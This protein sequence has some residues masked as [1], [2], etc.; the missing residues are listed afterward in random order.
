MRRRDFLAA[1]GGLLIWPLAVRAQQPA[2]PVIG[3]LSSISEDASTLAAFHR[4]LFQEGYVEGRNV[5]IEHRYARGQYDRLPALARELASVNVI[6]AVGSSPA[7]LAAKAATPNIPIVF[8]LGAD[9]VGLGLVASYNSPGGNITGVSITPTSLTPKRLE[10]LDGLVAKGAPL[11]L[12]VNPTNRLLDE[13]LKLAHDAARLLARDLVVLKAGSQADIDAAFEALARRQARGL[14]IW[15]E[16]FLNSRRQQIVAL[17][18]RQAIP[19]VYPWRAAVEADG[20]M[21][22]GAD[23]GDAYRQVGIYTGRIL[24][25][26]KPADL[27][28]LQP[29]KFEFV[30]NLKTARALDLAIP[31]K[32]LALADAVIE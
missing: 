16:A 7:A 28:V 11:A 5:R 19:A 17:A 29:T 32:L 22:Y 20:L 13:E 18:A 23:L 30:I 6:A 4:G 26:A 10:L 24:K 15:Q 3:F 1:F 2:M 9:V 21:S 8:F 14:V 12:L 31:P 27:P 25:G